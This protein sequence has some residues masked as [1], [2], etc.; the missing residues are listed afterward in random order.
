LIEVWTDGSA[1]TRQKGTAI[2]YAAIIVIG[3]YEWRLSAWAPEGTNNTAE[4][5]AAIIGLQ[6]LNPEPCKRDGVTVYTDSEYVINQATFQHATRA[7]H[8]LVKQLQALSVE[9]GAQWIHVKGH[10]GIDCNERVDR[11]AGEARKAY[12]GSG[13]SSLHICDLVDTRDNTLLLSRGQAKR[14]NRV[15]T[16]TEWL[17]L[18]FI[19]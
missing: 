3:E 8:E 2:G 10:T 14:S 7:N 5:K 6:A 18:E 4:L 11:L 16:G 9:R 12:N 19:P 15:W 17:D 1:L 13:L